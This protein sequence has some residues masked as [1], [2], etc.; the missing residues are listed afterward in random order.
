MLD[1]GDQNDRLD[2]GSGTDNLL[3]GLGNDTIFARDLI[4]DLLDGG[5]GN[6]SAHIDT[7]DSRTNIEALLA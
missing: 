1:G 4:A 3:G 2:G 7:I 6:D 5:D